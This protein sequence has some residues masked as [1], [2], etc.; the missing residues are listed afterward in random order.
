[1]KTDIKTKIYNAQCIGNVEPIEYM[2]P[3][4][5]MR[6]LIEGQTIKFSGQIMNEISNIT[7]QDF[8]DLVMQTSNWLQSIG[9]EP[10]Q[11][12]IVPELEHLECQ[13]LLFGIWNMGCSAVFTQGQNIENIDK[14]IVDA[15]TVRLNDSLFDTIKAYS[16]K[17]LAKHKPLLSDEAVLSFEKESGIRLSHYNLLINVNGIQKAIGLE[18]RTSF[19]CDLRTGSICWIIF[20][21]IL[22]VHCGLIYNNKNS[23]LTIGESGKDYNLRRDLNNLSSFASNDI[24]ICIENTAALSINGEPIHL[25]DYDMLNDGIRVRGHSV[26]MG[27]LDDEI[28]KVA[29]ENSGLKISF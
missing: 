26:M 5:S 21:A 14:R 29:F 6:S 10:K 7:N 27:Y 22:P 4:P 18:S 20:Q 3:Y 23:K 11:R 1:M 2:T 13:I 15:Q 24:A 12:V 8:F 16:N 9:I 28:N 19:Y 25:S 17:Y